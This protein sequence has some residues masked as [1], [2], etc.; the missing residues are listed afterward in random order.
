MIDE[1]DRSF[2]KKEVKNQKEQKKTNVRP[3]G[4]N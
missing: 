3:T 2:R 4:V 1:N